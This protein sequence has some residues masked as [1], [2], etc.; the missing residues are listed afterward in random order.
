MTWWRRLLLAAA[1]A[2][3]AGAAQAATYTN[4]ATTFA[5]IDASAHTQ[6]GYNTA[7]YQFN[8][9]VGSSTCGTAPPVIDDTI[10]D[11]IPIGFNFFFGTQTFDRVRIMSNGR[12]QLANSSPAY[13]NT[14]CGYGSPVQQ[15]PISDAGLNYTM[16]IFGN[17]LDPTLQSD[18]AGYTTACKSRT[19]AS[20]CFVSYATIGTAPNR[21]F[22]VTW[23]NVPEW[24]ATN[25]TTGNYNIQLILQEDGDFIYQYGNDTPGPGATTGQIAWQVSTT[26]YDSVAAG[27]PAA[28]TAIRFYTPKPILEYRMEEAIW[29]G[30]GSVID[31]SSSGRNGGPVGAAQT[32][33]FGKVCRGANIPSAGSNAIDTATSVASIGNSGMIA[34]WYKANTAWSG[35]GTQDVQLFDATTTSGQWFFLVRRGGTGANA[36]KLRFVITDSGGTVRI[37]ETPVLSVASNTWKHVAVTWTLNNLATGNNDRLTVYVDGVQQAQTTF[38]STTLTLSNQLG[39]LY[40]GGSRSGI[41]GQ[42][43][44]INSA[45][46]V[47]DE[48][49]V[50]NYEAPASKVAQVM[51]QIK[52]LCLNH[53]QITNAGSAP[54]CLPPQVTVTAHALDHTQLA[55]T[56]NIQLSTSTGTGIWSLLSGRGVLAGGGANNGTATYQFINESQVVLALT[57]AP[58][59]VTTHVTDGTFSE[60]ENG[61][62]TI[63]SCGTGRFNACEV[64]APRCTPSAASN[65]Y[66]RLFTKLASTGF[67]LDFVAL[68]AGLL[69]T[70]FSK[71]VGVAFL[72]NTNTPTLSAANNCPT[73][74]TAAIPLGN[75]T[76]ASGRA[77]ASIAANAFSNVAPN[78]AAYR[79]VRVQFTCTAA[80]CGSAVTVCA[81][82][83]FSV[84]PAAFTVSSPNANADSAGANAGATP[85]LI[86][87]SAT[88]SLVADAATPGYDGMPNFDASKA[89]WPGA[90]AGGRAGGVG[91]V[92]GYFTKPATI[93]T[94]NGATG[95]NFLYDEAGYFRLKGAGIYD[96]SFAGWSG[97][98][99]NGDCIAGSYSN[100][101]DATG[102]IG[103]LIANT[104]ATNHFGRF[105]PSRFDEVLTPG[106]ASGATPYTYSAQPFGLRLTAVNASGATT[107]NYSQSFAQAVTL[108]EANGVTGGSLSPTNLVATAFTGGVANLT[109]SFTFVRVTPDHAPA[110]IKPRATDVDGVS[111]ATG[112]EGTTLIRIGRLRLS[113][114]YG[115]KSPLV[116]PVAAQYWTGSSWITNADD[117]CTPLVTANLQM[118]PAGWGVAAPNLLVN[119][120][121]S[122]TLTPTGPG[123]TS[124]CADLGPDNG[125]T[126]TATSAAL[127]WLQSKWPGGAGYNN[128]PSA[129]A[130]FGVFS[131]EGKRGVYSREM[132]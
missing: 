124:V 49:N 3:F 109:P 84:R 17:D 27:Y 15:L 77:T 28:G 105:I 100:T 87:G 64:A 16:R 107:Q 13:D 98:V 71:P 22:V 47:L 11:Q 39:T 81:P 44:T 46:A 92:W 111:S 65:A 8:G 2:F 130:T 54:T 96:I 61:A 89:E 90:P 83:A 6:V 75:V 129:I 35:S 128:D 117:R 85:R 24:A 62:L 60:L 50:F 121:G 32:T 40:L 122:V 58:A 66:A 38:T 86:A 10:S 101:A 18:A 57:H 68:S 20:A 97:D 95:T 69:D 12:L 118:T 21:R 78:R 82:D 74:Q 112:T 131:P 67:T 70:T 34:F 9:T 115:Y 88:F 125:V 108:T 99:G 93:A 29:T 23:N 73:S 42:S 19:G 45:D 37:A 36:G 55:I 91:S 103:C 51:T 102:R 110:T 53:Y 132:Y 14:T 25:S 59:A 5:W 94:G 43:G 52:T 1:L 116:M 30:S 48:V 104:A 31:S 126:C 119:G 114:V 113:S 7:P 26:D 127:P 63:T 80:N 41:A 4:A 33:T 72:A 56:G 120:A 79:D 76:F 106:C 123:S